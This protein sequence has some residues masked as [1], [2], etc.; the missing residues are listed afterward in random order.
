MEI[1]SIITIVTVVVTFFM[2]II[3]KKYEL[4]E[5]KYIP[6]QNVIIGIIA[7]VICYG[8]RLDNMNLATSIVTCIISALGAGGAYDLTR[9]GGKE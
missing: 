9:T 7:G 3:S 5:S 2:G 6:I 8:L 4:V 1:T